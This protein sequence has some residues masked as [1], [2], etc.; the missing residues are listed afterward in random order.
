MM[1]RIILKNSLSVQKKMIE[2]CKNKGDFPN[3]GM[4]NRQ[5]K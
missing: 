5:T 2:M 3:L 4:T 1:K